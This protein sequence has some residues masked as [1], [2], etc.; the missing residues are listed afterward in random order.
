LSQIANNLDD[1]IVRRPRACPKNE[2]DKGTNNPSE[3][4]NI[5]LTNKILL[6][7]N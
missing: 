7:E 3:E 6:N 5:I 4:L 1:A 2:S